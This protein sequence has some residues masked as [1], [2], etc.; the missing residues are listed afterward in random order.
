M[1]WSRVL[2]LTALFRSR[3]ASQATFESRRLFASS[4][5]GLIDGPPA[6][7]VALGAGRIYLKLWSIL[8]RKARI[9]K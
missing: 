9:C 7:R 1:A 2:Q 3:Q 5:G 8:P 4:S 6:R